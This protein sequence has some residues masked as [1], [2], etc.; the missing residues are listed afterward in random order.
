M[1]LWLLAVNTVQA[2]DAAKPSPDA[3]GA[4]SKPSATSQ[5]PDKPP[6]EPSGLSPDAEL[7]KAL[8]KHAAPAGAV[9][10]EPLVRVGRRMRDVQGRLSQA[11]AGKETRGIQKE[12]VEDLEKLIEEL[13]KGGG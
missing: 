2:D 9:E 7:L 8:E 6:P 3:D 10:E 12:I 1:A 4:K 11:D 13:K 5:D